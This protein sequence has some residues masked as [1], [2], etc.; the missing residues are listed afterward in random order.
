MQRWIMS[1]PLF[2][3]HFNRA[4]IAASLGTCHARR[5]APACARRICRHTPC[6]NR[7]LTWRSPRSP[8]GF[9]MFM[10]HVPPYTLPELR[11]H[12]ALAIPA[13]RFCMRMLHVP[14]YTLPE[15]R[16]H[17]ALATPADRLRHAH[18]ACAALHSAGITASLG[19][20]HA[21]RQ[22]SA[23]ACRTY[24]PTLC[25]NHGFTQHSPCPT[26][27]FGMRMSHMPPCSM[28]ASR[29]HSAL[30]IPAARL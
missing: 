23:C 15:S 3:I 22:A 28:P 5:Q 20:R 27:G 17:S 18:V 29:L 30:A 26:T 7:G 14:P 24:R 12:S 16:L 21:R 2:S 10:S 13:D 8:T 19:T 11:L 4:I 9:G 6:R 25:R 1:P